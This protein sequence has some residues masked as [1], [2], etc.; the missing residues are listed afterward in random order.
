MWIAA[1][2]R[3]LGPTSHMDEDLVAGKVADEVSDDVGRVGKRRAVEG[4]GGEY[5]EEPMR[6]LPKPCT[7]VQPKLQLVDASERW[8][9]KKATPCAVNEAESMPAVRR[10]LVRQAARVCCAR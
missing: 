4:A 5:A 1:V 8:G 10:P 2:E 6:G 9:G 3:R 7:R